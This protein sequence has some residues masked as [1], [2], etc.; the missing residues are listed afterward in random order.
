MQEIIRGNHDGSSGGSATFTICRIAIPREILV[1][2]VKGDWHPGYHTVRV[3][4]PSRPGEYTEYVRA[5]P[6]RIFL[7]NINKRS[8]GWF[9]VA[10]TDSGKARG[11]TQPA[12]AS[13][14]SQAKMIEFIHG[15]RDGEHLRNETYTICRLG[16]PAARLVD[17][18]EAGLHPGY[19]VVSRDGGR[20]PVPRPGTKDINQTWQ[21]AMVPPRPDL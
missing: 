8:G 1:D 3:K 6:D 18:I 15:N 13:T 10:Q 5:N 20:I 21:C 12:E 4:Q 17:E 9:C 16:V 2:E 7:N 14:W 11:Q 19:A